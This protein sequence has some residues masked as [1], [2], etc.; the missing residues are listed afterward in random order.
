MPLRLGIVD[1]AEDPDAAVRGLSGAP[2]SVRL[3]AKLLR[4]VALGEDSYWT[5]YIKVRVRPMT[6]F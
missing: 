4:E 3:A 1:W 2:W 6:R 5:P